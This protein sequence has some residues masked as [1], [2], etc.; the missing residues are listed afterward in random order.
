MAVSRIRVNPESPSTSGT[1]GRRYAGVDPEERQR[2]RKARLVEGALAVFGEKGFHPATVRDVCKEA[3]LTSRYFYESFDSMEALFRSVYA[4]ISR[5]LMQ[6][7]IMALAQCPPDP[8]KLTEAALRTFLGFIQEDPRRARVALID[9]LNVGEGMNSLAN[10]ASQ[11]Y[12][13]LVSTFVH[14][15][16]PNMAELGLNPTII[17]DGLVGSSNRIATQWVAEKCKTPLDEV[18]HNCLSIFKACIEMA[19]RGTT[20]PP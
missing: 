10:K 12:A 18:L 9:A 7:T 13:Q 4:S 3:K 8:E 6:A 2:Q 16:F 1:T 19:R 11:D 5:E 17:A 14:Q 20:T 15:F